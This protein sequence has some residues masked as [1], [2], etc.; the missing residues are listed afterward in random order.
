MT[1]STTSPARSPTVAISGTSQA[2]HARRSQRSIAA[3]TRMGI[4]TV[5]AIYFLVPVYWLVIAATKLDGSLINSPALLLSR[6]QLFSNLR[7]LFSFEN[8]IFVRWAL[9]SLLYSVVGAGV[10]TIIAGMAGYYLAMFRFKGREVVFSIIIAGML[11]PTTALALPLFLIFAKLHMA[12]TYWAVFLSSIVSPFSLY[13]CRLSAQAFVPPE[14]L[15]AGRIDGAS[16]G[17]IFVSVSARLMF[18]GL[19]TAFL[20][21]FV[22]IWNNFLLPLVMLHSQNLYPLTLGLYTWNGT[23]VTDPLIQQDIIVGSL[24]SVVPLLIAFLFLQ[25]YWRTGLAAGQRE[26]VR[27]AEISLAQPGG[28]PDVIEAQTRWG[29]VRGS[30][31]RWRDCLPRYPV[32]CADLGDG[33]FRPP[34]PPEAWTGVFDARADGPAASSVTSSATSVRRQWLISCIRATATRWRGR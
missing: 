1:T 12:D 27:N 10:G 30:R 4:L 15:E 5:A 17:R 22:S 20:T 11:I 21:Q 3:V 24:V 16:D 28:V 8:D 25:R 26:G 23:A 2:R 9:N 33:R 13:V 29:R 14:L 31:T 19:A 32:W 7:D 18:P 6:P 34:R